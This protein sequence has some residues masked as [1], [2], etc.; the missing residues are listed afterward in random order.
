MSKRETPQ[1]FPSPEDPEKERIIEALT[2]GDDE[3][4]KQAGGKFIEGLSKEDIEYD[5]K[6]RREKAAKEAE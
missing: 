1:P 6:L 2:K 5:T 4:L 3:A